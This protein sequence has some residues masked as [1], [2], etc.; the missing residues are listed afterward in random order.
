VKANFLRG[1]NRNQLSPTNEKQSPLAIHADRE[2]YIRGVAL[3]E[4]RPLAGMLHKLI[5]EAISA[6]QAA[7]HQ[8]AEVSRLTAVL[9][10]ET[11]ESAH[12]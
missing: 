6:R 8:V 11:A 4:G 9:R 7:A 12:D 2:H 10:G 5:S 3:K 1:E